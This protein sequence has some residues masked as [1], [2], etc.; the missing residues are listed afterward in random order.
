MDYKIESSRDIQDLVSQVK[1]L[2]RQ[3]WVPTGGVASV[4]HELHGHMLVQAMTKQN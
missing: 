1:E 4:A 2:V 3:G